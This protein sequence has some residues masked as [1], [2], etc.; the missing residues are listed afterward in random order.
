M[1]EQSGIQE[2]LQ[3][4][5]R[6]LGPG[7]CPWD[8][9]QTP[10]SLCD[11]LVEETFELVTAIRSG[12]NEE[13]QEELGDVFFLL[14][15]MSRLLQDRLSLE[16]ALKMSSRKMIRRH[17]H[18]FG[19]KEVDSREELIQN[20]EQIKQQEKSRSRDSIL[21][22]VPKNLPPMLLAYRMNAKAA[23]AGFTWDQDRELEDKLDEEWQEW[24]RA[25]QRGDKKRME[26]E[27]GDYLFTLVEYGRRHN[28]KANSALAMTNSKFLRRLERME[29]LAL[30]KGWDLSQ[31][32]MEHLEGLWQEAKD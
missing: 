27:F 3:V 1:Q 16:Q 32:D 9:E 13:I 24:S 29:E 2:L 26:E 5:E 15:F 28:I 10:E 14:L 30:E 11:Y 20:W 23:R 22:S 21:G 18:V 4:I 12:K 25:R 19:H 7:G 31:L 6:L 8:Q 17:P